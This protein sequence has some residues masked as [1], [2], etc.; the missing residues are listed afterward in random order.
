MCVCVCVCV[1]LCMGVSSS[2]F[3]KG[4]L[5]LWSLRRAGGCERDSLSVRVQPKETSRRST[6][7]AGDRPMRNI[8]VCI[9]KINMQI[10]KIQLAINQVDG[11]YIKN[12]LINNIQHI[13]I[14]TDTVINI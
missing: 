6:S 14:P 4:L 9:H 10:S 7:I 5:R 3:T 12:T 13:D 11:I 1:C 8:C 2:Y